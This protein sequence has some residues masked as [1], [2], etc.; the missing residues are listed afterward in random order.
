M[1]IKEEF[2][3]A[4]L[5]NIFIDSNFYNNLNIINTNI[6]FGNNL[7][8]DLDTA[9]TIWFQ[10]GGTNHYNR[11]ELRPDAQ[12]IAIGDNTNTSS[13]DK[14][15]TSLTNNILSFQLQRFNLPREILFSTGNFAKFDINSNSTSNINESVSNLKS[16]HNNTDI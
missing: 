9:E 13:H 12:G 10:H 16:W 6:K 3:D 7:S 2:S 5:S 1:K 15:L 4:T 8:W 14:V 11:I